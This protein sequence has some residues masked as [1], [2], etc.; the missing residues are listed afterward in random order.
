MLSKE[1]NQALE[2]THSKSNLFMATLAS[3]PTIPALRRR[4][5]QVDL[6]VSQASMVYRERG[7]KEEKEIPN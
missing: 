3:E 7:R 5:R 4:P 2:N 6:C 1:K